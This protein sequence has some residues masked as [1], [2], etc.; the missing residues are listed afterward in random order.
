MVTSEVLTVGDELLEGSKV[1]TNAAW[2]AET[3]TDAGGELVRI[4]TVGDDPSTISKEIKRAVSE[5]VDLVILTGGLGPTPDDR[6][7]EALSQALE[8]RRRLDER[9]RDMVE[10]SYRDFAERGLIEEG[11]VTPSR[12]KMA[13]L[14]EGSEPINNPIG[15]A[16]AV[17]AERENTKI[18]C[19]PGVPR[20]MKPIFQDNLDKLGLKGGEGEKHVLTLNVVGSE[21]SALAPLYDDLQDKFAEVEVRSYPEYSKEDDNR[22]IVK[23]STEDEERLLEVEDYFRELVEKLGSARIKSSSIRNQ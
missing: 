20:E 2:I 1:N 11:G 4:T 17:L 8:V 21:E 23:L 19:M 22:I 16:P 18:F 10:E 6:T 13:K 7:L 3:V 15:G 12:E 5:G 9:A 14:P